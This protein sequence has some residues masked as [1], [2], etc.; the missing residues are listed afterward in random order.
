MP[1]EEDTDD[2][3]LNVDPGTKDPHH[4]KEWNDKVDK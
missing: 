1:H 3:A 2:V 4:S